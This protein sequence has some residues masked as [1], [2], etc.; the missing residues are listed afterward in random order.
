MIRATIGA[1]IPLK[2]DVHGESTLLIHGVF[3]GDIVLDATLQ[4]AGA[5]S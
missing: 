5:S 1:G 2:G 3:E 4:V